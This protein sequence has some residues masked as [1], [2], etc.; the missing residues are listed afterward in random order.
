MTGESVRDR[1]RGV[2]WGW[3]PG[4]ATAGRSA[5]PCAWAK[6][7]SNSAGSIPPLRGAARPRMLGVGLASWD[8]SSLIPCTTTRQPGVSIP[9][10]P[11]VAVD[12]SLFASPSFRSRNS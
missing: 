12:G 10:H 9:R 2:F 1:C 6:A 3:L 4:I 5:W 7:C 8:V 11:V